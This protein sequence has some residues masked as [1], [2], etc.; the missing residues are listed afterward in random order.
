M[1]EVEKTR[2]RDNKERSIL[3]HP[4]TGRQNGR[5]E[6][7]RRRDEVQ[8]DDDSDEFESQGAQSERYTQPRENISPLTS[9]AA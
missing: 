2:M 6:C 1:V 3:A 4:R 9:D 8:A 7:E 5:K